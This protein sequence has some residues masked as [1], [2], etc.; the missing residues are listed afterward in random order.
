MT[1]T[2]SSGA[3]VTTLI[4]GYLGSSGVGFYSDSGDTLTSITVTC[5]D[6]TGFAIG[7]FGIDTGRISGGVGTVPEPATIII[8][9]LLGGLGLV[10]AL[11]KRKAA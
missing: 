3:S 5:S 1:A 8:W 6:T 7:E 9:S 11:R 10:F 2:D 4:N